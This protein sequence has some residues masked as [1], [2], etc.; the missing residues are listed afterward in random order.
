MIFK[1]NSLPPL[2]SGWSKKIEWF[3]CVCVYV[4]VWVHQQAQRDGL[5]SPSSAFNELDFAHQGYFYNCFDLQFFFKE[6]VCA[7]CLPEVAFDM[8]LPPTPISCLIYFMVGFIPYVT[9]WHWVLQ[10]G[11]W[12]WIG[13]KHFWTLQGSNISDVQLNHFCFECWK[14]L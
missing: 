11:D 8:V 10:R 4:W 13:L 12:H 6:V 2:I 7:A 9:F 14:A 1:C 3:W 5:H